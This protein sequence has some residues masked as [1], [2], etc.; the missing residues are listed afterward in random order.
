MCI[1]PN[2]YTIL[3]MFQKMTPW[4]KSVSINLSGGVKL[5]TILTVQIMDTFRNTFGKQI[6]LSYRHCYV[7]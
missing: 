6:N 3:Q 5:L 2:C 1:Q 4:N 7:N